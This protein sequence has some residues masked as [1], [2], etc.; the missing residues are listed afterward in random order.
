V[1]RVLFPACRGRVTRPPRVQAGA[2]GR[3]RPGTGPLLVGLRGGQA[4][5]S[6]IWSVQPRPPLRTRPPPRR[7]RSAARPRPRG[8]PSVRPRVARRRLPRARPRA[9]SHPGR[10]MGRTTGA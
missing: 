7:M 8:R 3:R 9:R 4:A 10:R 2:A 6:P 5:R 1:E